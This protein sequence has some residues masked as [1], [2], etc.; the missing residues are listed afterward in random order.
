M[1]E[2]ILDPGRQAG[3]CVHDGSEWRKAKGDADGHAQVDVL[4]SALP[5][6]AAT[7]ATL[8]SLLTELQQKLETADLAIDAQKHLDTHK[9]PHSSEVKL[10]ARWDITVPAD[11]TI[12]VLSTTSGCGRVFAC[13]LYVDGEDWLSR[14][15]EIWFYIDGEATPSTII[16]PDHIYWYLCGGRIVDLNLAG[17]VT[18]DTTN[19]I[20]HGWWA[21]G[22]SFESSIRVVIKNKDTANPIVVRA[23]VWIEWLK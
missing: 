4:S 7:E 9:I 11:G 12:E 22:P 15:S 23:G 8:S 21:F 3:I 20:Y 19:H 10:H 17:I 13:M 18:W 6:G 14:Y 2:P 5:S 16:S 1:G